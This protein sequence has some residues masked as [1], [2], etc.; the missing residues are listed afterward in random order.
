[1]DGR[2]GVTCCVEAGTTYQIAAAT[3][4]PTEFMLTYSVSD[5]PATLDVTVFTG[6][7]AIEVNGTP[8]A[9]PYSGSYPACD[10][11]ELR[12][13]PTTLGWKFLLWAGDVSSTENPVLVS[14]NG[15]KTVRAAF[16][17]C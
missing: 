8:E 15:D 16:R 13:V 11:V 14:M 17:E 1:V 9:L 2:R 6:Q 3:V 10:T 5:A 12:G 4:D 7:G